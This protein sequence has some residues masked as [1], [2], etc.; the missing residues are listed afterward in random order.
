MATQYDTQIQQLYVAYFNRPADASGIA[1]WTNAMANGT[2][3]AQISAAF[4]QSLEYQ[5]EYSQS[6]NAGIVNAVYQ[7]LFGRPAE[8]DGLAFWVKALNDKSITVDNM[9]EF[10]SRGAQGTDK[11]AFDSKVTVATAFTNALDTDAEK[12]G[13]AGTDANN[14]AKEMLAKITTAAQATA[15]IEK[16]ALDAS[17]AAVIK[18]G[19]PFTLESGLAALGAAQDAVDA[20][21]EDF[22]DANDMDEATAEDVEAAVDAA[23]EDLV[24]LIENDGYS[25]ASDGVK[26]AMIADQQELNAKTLVEANKALTAAQDAVAKVTGLGNAIAAATSAKAAVEAAQDEAVE[27]QAAYSSAATIFMGRNENSAI[28]S[29]TITVDGKTV[30]TQAADG[31]WKVATGVTASTYPGLSALVT[32]ANNWTAANEEIEAAQ[33]A[34]TL[35]QLRVELLDQTAGVLATAFDFTATEPKDE[36]K[37]TYNEIVNELSALSAA[38]VTA[39]ARLAAAKP[40]D[41]NY[42]DLQQAAS[43]AASDLSDFQG[44]ITA[45]NR[46]NTTKLADDVIAA[47]SGTVGLAMAAIAEVDGLSEAMA[48]AAALE[49]AETAAATQKAA[50]EDAAANSTLVVNSDGTVEDGNGDIIIELDGGK[51]QPVDGE[52][53]SAYAGVTAYISAFNAVVDAALTTD[54]EN[55]LLDTDNIALIGDLEAAQA[56]AATDDL[57]DRAEAL[58]T[59][60]AQAAIDDLA[61]ALEALED[62]QAAADELEGLQDAVDEAV[63]DFT[64]EDYAAPITLGASNFGTT[65]SDIF[66]AGTVNSTVTNF[67]RSGDDVLF[68]GSGYTLNEGAL[69][70]GD[71]AVLEVF[72][73]QSGNNAVITIESKAYGSDSGDVHTVT[74]TGV[75]VD[76]LTFEN[77]IITL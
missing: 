5:V 8:T 37:P 36:T 22:A 38:S 35:A 31:T 52:D 28:N 11:V 47:E 59:E 19:T 65:D 25:A 33:E 15:A 69:S 9:V 50:F 23:Q 13:Y 16:A 24:E 73:R 2:T 12:A 32:A 20:F 71:D 1:F 3:V 58:G 57:A 34:A 4:A 66:V 40:T 30:A 6:T 53:L 27:V 67:G 42:A 48:A 51:L 72:F 44:Q 74:L 55:L 76:D 56:A 39:D 17:V 7:N 41:A 60:G 21:L 62:A 64:A 46:N 68:V 14:A 61:E 75:N 70:T 49:A 54:E 26:A 18:A 63:A 43:D 77:G 10:I 45:F 29:G